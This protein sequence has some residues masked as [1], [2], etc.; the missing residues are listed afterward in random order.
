MLRR[1]NKYTDRLAAQLA[2]ARRQEVNNTP[3]P[4]VF[5]VNEYLLKHR[6]VNVI[7]TNHAREQC[8]K[9]DNGM[10]I[11]T[12]RAYFKQVVDGLVDFNWKYDD[13]EIF[14]YNRHY[15]R[16]VI[17][18]G[19]RDYKAGPALALVIVTIYPYGKSRPMKDSTE[20]V[21]V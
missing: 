14:V 2:G 17:L 13:Q 3:G 19:R 5:K 16:G 7:V 10:A 1:S 11:E 18:T 9:R 21:Y 12:M 15:Q 8:R 6:G 20:V 4:R